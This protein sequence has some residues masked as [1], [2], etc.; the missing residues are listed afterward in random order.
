MQI[1]FTFLIPAYPGNPRQNPE[2]HKTA[3]VVVV[4]KVASAW[5]GVSLANAIP[6]R[7]KQE[8]QQC[9]A[10]RDNNL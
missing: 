5:D 8:Q 7:L 6:Q 9:N 10:I 2:S 3:A 4:L 1:G